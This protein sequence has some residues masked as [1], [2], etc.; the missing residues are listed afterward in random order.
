MDCGT[1]GL[2]T[3][4]LDTDGRLLAAARRPYPTQ[5]GREGKAEQD[6]DDWWDALGATVRQVLSDPAVARRRLLA[7]GVGGQMHGLVVLDAVGQPVRPAIVW[8][9]TRSAGVCARWRKQFGDAAFSALAGLPIAT[10]FLAS[11]LAWLRAA[12]PERFA[13][14]RTVLP[15]KDELRRRLT[16]RTATD[17]SDAG[18]TLLFDVQA[19][20]WSRELLRW[21]GLSPAV[22]PPVLPSTSIGGTVTEAAASASGLPAG[23]PVVVGGADQPL[24]ALALGLDDGLAAVSIG[25][26][27]TVLLPARA[28][29]RPPASPAVHTL[30]HVLPGRRLRMGAILAAGGAFEWLR[31]TL[32]TPTGHP[33]AADDLDRAAGDVAPGADGLLFL[34][35]LAGERTPLLDPDRSGAFLGLRTEH[36][37]PHLVRAVEEGVVFAL[38]AAL[39]AAL[40]G[41]PPPPQVLLTGGGSRGE[42]WPR[43]VA[44]VLQVPVTVSSTGDHSAIGAAMVAAIAA[45][46]I[47]GR[48][49]PRDWA[50]RHLDAVRRIE[51]RPAQAVLYDRL[52][53]LYQR[54]DDA[55]AETAHAL[56]QLRR[57]R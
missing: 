53:A 51:V 54:A 34:P 7:I 36:G 52:F 23:T 2:R 6:P 9:D 49:P 17:P 10:G 29:A 8:S 15:P 38:R 55:V 25:T 22:L 11:S 30:C 26:G 1:S 47:P 33:A 18:G 12:E 19:E 5:V 48:R 57:E 20:R 35:H 4:V 46:L 56:R 31:S 40:D 45:G 50:H 42:T 28:S 24:S 16:G 14:I 27:G 32:S 13:R 44:D 39:E 21:T 43:I 37:L 41:A 3:V